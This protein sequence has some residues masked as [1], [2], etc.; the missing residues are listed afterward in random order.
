VGTGSQLQEFKDDLVRH[1]A[2]QL[3]RKYILDGPCY[4][5]SPT[6]HM[7]LKEAVSQ[8]FSIQFSEVT[9]VGSAKLG[10]SLKPQR[11]YG[12]F[13]DTSDID[14]AIISS[15]LFVRV[16]EEVYMYKA[17]GAYWPNAQSFFDYLAFGWIRPDKLPPSDTFKFSNSWWNFFRELTVSQKF[18]PY[19]IRA[20]LYHSTFFLEQYQTICIKQCQTEA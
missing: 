15:N 1:G 16:W 20:G 19:N 4:A 6:L 5:L 12:A 18:G 9:L 14:I 3:F 8:H 2:I 10:F 7:E 11:R 17:T 13:C